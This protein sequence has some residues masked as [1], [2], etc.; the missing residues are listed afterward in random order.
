MLCHDNCRLVGTVS[1][2][3]CSIFCSLIWFYFEWKQPLVFSH[4]IVFFF[5]FLLG[6]EI[7]GGFLIFLNFMGLF[8]FWDGNNWWSSEE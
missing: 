3:I 5:M 2:L 7:T 1:G 8:F 4:H 6:M